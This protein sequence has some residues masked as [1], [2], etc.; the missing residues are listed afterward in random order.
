MPAL[1]VHAEERSIVYANAPSASEI[2]T[3]LRRVSVDGGQWV[4]PA[5]R[6][7]RTAVPGERFATHAA[8]LY[9][10]PDT[11]RDPITDGRA[12]RV[13]QAAQAALDA[14]SIGWQPVEVI[15]YSPA[16]HGPLSWWNSGEAAIT[17][18]GNN[19]PE[20]GGRFD[21]AENP[22]GP[23]TAQ[24]HPTTARD[25][26]ARAAVGLGEILTPLVIIAGLGLGVYALDR[27]GLLS[28]RT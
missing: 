2:A 26:A 5:P 11:G 7:T 21:A 23:T 20:M 14:V 28:R 6:V 15:P 17:Q 16:L 13:Q 8:W 12:G 22:I 1:L 25:Q 19:L 24:T 18:T 3:A 27:A 9:A 10:W 4:G